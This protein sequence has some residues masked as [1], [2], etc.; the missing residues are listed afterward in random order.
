MDG[1]GYSD[2]FEWKGN[3]A[4]PLRAASFVQAVGKFD[5]VLVPQCYGQNFNQECSSFCEEAYRLAGRQ[6]LFGRLPLVFD[7]RDREREQKLIP[8]FTKPMILVHTQGISSAFHQGRELFESLKPLQDEYE[9]VDLSLVKAHRF[10]DLLGLYEKAEYLVAIDSGPLHLAQAVPDLKVIA[11]ITDGPTPWHGT[12]PRKNHVLRIPYSQYGQRKHEIP[13]AIRIKKKT[14][15]KLIHV[16]SKYH[17]GKQD[18]Q[19]RHTVA[20]MTWDREMQGW[21]D[22][23][24]LDTAFARNARTDFNDLKCAPYVT[25]M[26]DK[27]M[28]LANPWDIVVLTNDDTCVTPNLTRIVRDVLAECGAC[29]GARREHNRVN[30][31]LTATE[32]MQGYKHVGADIFCFHKEWWIEHG[33]N[34]PDM[35]MAFENW[36]YV[37][38]TVI[39]ENGGREIEGLCYHEIHQG[40]WLKN[41]TLAA[42]KHNQRMGGEFFNARGG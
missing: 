42:A 19:R 40:D 34:M 4:D 2:K 39:N 18:A 21:I 6:H 5:Q 35:L 26:I 7:R 24:L 16:W 30:H 10:Y 31:P 38:R 22:L 17:I 14:E 25:D 27:A 36:D 12:P 11:L 37:L 41:R 1:V 28:M 23:P 15:S 3:Y 29:W 33:H 8:Q 20:K 13:E 32:L 9:I